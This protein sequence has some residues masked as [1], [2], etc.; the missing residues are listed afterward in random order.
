MTVCEHEIKNIIKHEIVV[1][2]GIILFEFCGICG[3]LVNIFPNKKLYIANY[4]EHDEVKKKQ[5]L[6]EE[7]AKTAGTNY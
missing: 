2:R 5:R 3:Q 6:R 1:E 7:H 4:Q